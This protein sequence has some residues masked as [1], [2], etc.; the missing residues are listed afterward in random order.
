MDTV[1]ESLNPNILKPWDIILYQPVPFT[2]KDS[3]G[4]TFDK[5]IAEKTWH[6]ICH[7]EVYTGH[8]TSI[9]ARNGV[10]VN[11]YP[12]RTA[13]AVHVLRLINPNEFNSLEAWKWFLKVRGQGYD[14]KGLLRFAYFKEIGSYSTAPHAMF[15]SEFAARFFANGNVLLFG[16]EDADAIAPFQ[17]ETT[18]LLNGIWSGV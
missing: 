11:Q 14:W 17:F 2:I 6:N 8:E 12:L 10:G 13:Q 16:G 3:I 15:C 7:V 1:M 4:W 9:A 5:L 18:P